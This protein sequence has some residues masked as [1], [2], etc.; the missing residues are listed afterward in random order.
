M[1]YTWLLLSPLK[2]PFTHCAGIERGAGRPCACSVIGH[3]NTGGGSSWAIAFLL[4]AA[5]CEKECCDVCLF[6]SCL[7]E[8]TKQRVVCIE[9]GNHEHIK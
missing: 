8:H 6:L 7:V 9:Q 1:I 3:K 4:W 2:Q 5:I